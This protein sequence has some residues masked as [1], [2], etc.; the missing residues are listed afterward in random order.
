MTQLKTKSGE[1]VFNA[2]VEATG[3]ELFKEDGKIV[4]KFNGKKLGIVRVP[5]V[6]V[7][8]KEVFISDLVGDID[9][10]T[11]IGKD[12]TTLTQ[13]EL[14]ALTTY[15]QGLAGAQ[16][17]ATTTDVEDE[18]EVEAKPKSK[19]KAKPSKPAPVVEEDEDE[20]EEE[21]EDEEAFELPEGLDTY[22]AI[23]ALGVKDMWAKIGKHVAAEAGIKARTPKDEMLDAIAEYFDLEPADDDEE[24]EEVKPKAKA[25][26]KAKPAPVEEEEDDEDDEEFDDED[27]DEFDDEDDDSDDID[28]EDDDDSDDDEDDDE[29]EDDFDDEDEDG[30]TE[31]DV[32]A[33]FKKND[34]AAIVKFCRE[35]GIELPQKKMSAALIKQIILD[36][37]FGDDDE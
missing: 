33:L 6:K 9:P 35:H 5:Q 36:E 26:A 7:G 32:E 3:V 12:P 30:V 2:Y 1:T 23:A 4:A 10:T 18:E 22:E 20:E 13:E 8:T 19:G 24:E 11:L 16:A 29:E 37:L 27:E 17:A 15:L 34:K 28:D 14:I 31:E 25:K 21:D